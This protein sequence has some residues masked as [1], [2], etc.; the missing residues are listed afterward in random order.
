MVGLFAFGDLLPLGYY[1]LFAMVD[2]IPSVARI[3]NVRPQAGDVNGDGVV[4]VSDLVKVILA[5]GPCPP[6][7]PP[8]RADVDGNGTV[9]VLDLLA[10]ILN[11]S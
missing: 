6:S 7:P 1:L 8:C 3:V 11:W 5:W 9:D 2:D 4:N 10:V